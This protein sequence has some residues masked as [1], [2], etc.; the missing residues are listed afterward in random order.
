MSRR[1][2]VYRVNKIQIVKLQLFVAKE[3]VH[4]AP[5]EKIVLQ[6]VVTHRRELASLANK[7]TIVL[8]N[9][10]YRESVKDVEVLKSASKVAA[11]QVY[12]PKIVSAMMSVHPICVRTVYV[13]NVHLLTIVRSCVVP[14]DAAWVL[15]GQMKTVQMVEHVNKGGVSVQMRENPV[16][17]LSIVAFPIC[18]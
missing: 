7:M 17:H 2:N 9:F 6:A 8:H 3:C 18:V 12:V 13:L 16:L 14:M 5:R 10:V 11:M 4:V 15:A 1:A